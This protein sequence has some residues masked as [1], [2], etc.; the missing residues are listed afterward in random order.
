[1]VAEFWNMLIRYMPI[2]YTATLITIK[3]SSLAIVIG[4]LLGLFSALGRM[5][6]NF[7]IRLPCN[8]YVW[9][10]RATPL[11]VQIFMIYFGLPQFGINLS[12]FVAGVIAMSINGGAYYAE[13]VRSGI[14]SVHYG[15][16]EAARSLG[17]SYPL[18]MRRIILP[19]AIKVIIP[20]F[21]NESIILIKDT[22]LLS[23][24][25][26]MEITLTA[27]RLISSTW[28]PFELYL[29]AAIYYA[30]ITTVLN[31]ALYKYEMKVSF[32]Q[33]KLE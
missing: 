10:F 21:G 3:I 5:S 23:T 12:P 18:S 13:I 1:M 22:S 14:Q 31:Y 16:L 2:F 33:Q 15:Q 7:I 17:M 29:I 8:F 30:I 19:Q 20:P 6:H 27:Q 28:K 4:F 24:I 32:S 25:T 26:I 11:L 9:F